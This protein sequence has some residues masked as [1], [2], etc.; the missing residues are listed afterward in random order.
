M[1]VTEAMEPSKEVAEVNR[2]LY[3]QIEPYCTGFLKVSDIHTIYWEQSGNPSGHVSSHHF[4]L[5]VKFVN[6]NQATANER[7]KINDNICGKY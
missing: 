2:N 3:P 4:V 6:P 1:S 5:L 7:N